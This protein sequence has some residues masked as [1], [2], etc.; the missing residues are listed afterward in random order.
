MQVKA[1]EEKL[2]MAREV[3]D[4]LEKKGVKLSETTLRRYVYKGIIP[5]ELIVP[6]RRGMKT[7]YYFKPKVVDYLVE[8]LSGD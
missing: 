7:Y 1:K 6:E 4:L 3:V 8:K 2:L 5:E